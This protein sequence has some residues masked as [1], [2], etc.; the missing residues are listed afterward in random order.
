MSDQELAL[1]Q[2]VELETRIAALRALAPVVP[3]ALAAEMN[4][5]AVVER[6]L[7]VA[8]QSAVDVASWVIADRGWREPR[9]YADTFN[10][11]SDEG[12]LERPLACRLAEMAAYR[13]VLVYGYTAV[14][15]E[16]TARFASE[17]LADL[18]ELAARFA[19][20]A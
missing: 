19:A 11:L 9:N 18:A 14:S 7:Q 17:G 8:V 15:H 10:V 20:T 12:F 3:E 2:L 13:N 1:R 16:I 4:V 6:H 5:A